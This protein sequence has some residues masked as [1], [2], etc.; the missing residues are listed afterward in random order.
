METRRIALFLALAFGIAWATS[1]IIYLTGGLQNSLVLIP[2]TPVTLALVLT[3]TLVMWAPAI[4]H[5]LTRPLTG[6]GWQAVGLRP[7]FK[8]AWPYWLA[9]WFLPGLLAIVGLAVFFIVFP[10]YF[11]PSLTT[12]RNLI[13]MA[14]PDMVLTESTLWLIVVAQIFQAL[15]IAPLI[16]GVATFGEEFGWRGY[17]QAKL[18][19]LGERKAILVLGLIWGVWHWPL[20]LMGHNYGLTY[21][22]APILGPLA[23]VWF[24]VI[25]SI[26]LGWVTLKSSSVWPAVIGHGAINGIAGLGAL[27]V[28]GTP[29]PILGPLPVG[30]IGGLGLSLFA[31]WLVLWPNSLTGV[32][33]TNREPVVSL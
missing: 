12:L 6:E 4:A 31:A 10:Q 9:A 5:I 7:R 2:N 15:L 16:N 30:V 8:R 17:L 3:T 23:M 1:L 22:G 14:A 11:D 20:I 24:T 29:N 25:F 18:M 13:T 19:P 28:Q 32:E 26:F 21:P 33:E 27:F